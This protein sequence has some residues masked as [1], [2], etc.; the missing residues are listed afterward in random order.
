MKNLQEGWR[1]VGGSCRGGL[2]LYD[3][4]PEHRS[5]KRRAGFGCLD[6]FDRLGVHMGILEGANFD[7]QTDLSELRGVFFPLGFLFLLQVCRDSLIPGR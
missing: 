7:E 1:Y 5:H 4:A 3:F 6:V 2:R